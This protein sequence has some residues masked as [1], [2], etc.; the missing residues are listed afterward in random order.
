MRKTIDLEL[1]NLPLNILPA[2]QRD[3]PHG[4]IYVE[5]RSA[6]QVSE[7]INGLVGISPSRGTNLVLIEETASLLQIKQQE[8]TVVPGRPGAGHGHD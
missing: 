2:F 6:K 3:S 5:A 4:V 1:S 8:L 7:A